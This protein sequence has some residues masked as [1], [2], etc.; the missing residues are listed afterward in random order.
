MEGPCS[1]GP[2]WGSYALPPSVLGKP[3]GEAVQGGPGA[4]DDRE[5]RNHFQATGACSPPCTCTA[6]A[7]RHPAVR[8]M[9]PTR[10]S[11]QGP[12]TGK[13]WTLASDPQLTRY[14]AMDNATRCHSHVQKD[15]VDLYI[16]R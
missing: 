9:A 7:D 8:V 5:L 15:K 3:H 4:E 12:V 10:C 16:Q 13:H 1:G 11:G 14:T 2:G 6:S